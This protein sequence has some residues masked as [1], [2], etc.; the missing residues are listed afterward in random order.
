MKRFSYLLLF[1]FILIGLGKLPYTNLVINSAV[2][3]VVLWIAATVLWR[4]SYRIQFKLSLVGIVLALGLTLA[5]RSDVAES[6]GNV[7]YFLLWIG[8]AGMIKERAV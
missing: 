6:M 3:F 2:F 8:L 5:G 1:F 4:I 7:V